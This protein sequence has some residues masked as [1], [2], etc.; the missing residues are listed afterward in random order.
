MAFIGCL[1]VVTSFEPLVRCWHTKGPQ[2]C[3]LAW[4]VSCLYVKKTQSKHCCVRLQ[5][6]FHLMVSG[7]V[8]KLLA[9]APR[10]DLMMTAC[11]VLWMICLVKGFAQVVHNMRRDTEGCD[12]MLQITYSWGAGRGISEATRLRLYSS[13]CYMKA[14]NKHD[15]NIYGGCSCFYVNF[16]WLEQISDPWDGSHTPR[17][18]WQCAC[19]W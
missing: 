11:A 9:A 15:H 10:V 1:L 4:N 6:L 16:Y 17:S 13:P 7:N 5:N 14:S 2:I 18:P 8:S 3:H 19:G 12:T